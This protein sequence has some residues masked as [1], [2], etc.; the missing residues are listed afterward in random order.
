MRRSLS[1]LAVPALV[2]ALAACAGDDGAAPADTSSPSSSSSSA[3]SDVPQRATGA[4]QEPTPG[5][6]TVELD[7]DGRPTVTIPDSAAPTETQVE[8]LKKGDGA[9]VADGDTVTVQ[10][11]GVNWTT[12]EVFDESWSRGAPATFATTQVITGFAQGM[13][14]QTVGSQT[15]VV[16][17]P[18]DGYGASGQPQAGIGGTD[19]LVF[20]IDILA[21]G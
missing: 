6:P 1:L 18:A 7:A 13:V 3:A 12:G 10:Y 20:V 21:V 15:V 16:I 5:F 4:D 17:P 2:L 11:Q 8:V 19:D 14:G 9:V